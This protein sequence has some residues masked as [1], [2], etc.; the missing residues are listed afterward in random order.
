MCWDRHSWVLAPSSSSTFPTALSLEVNQ[1]ALVTASSLSQGPSLCS[2][3]I[4][5]R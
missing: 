5:G 1:G 2:G 4:Q 3:D